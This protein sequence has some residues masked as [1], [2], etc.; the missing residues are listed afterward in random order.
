MTNSQT[1]TTHVNQ[2]VAE[3]LIGRAGITRDPDGR[4]LIPE[5]ARDLIGAHPFTWATDEALT[6]ALVILATAD[7]EALTF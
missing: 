7:V 4:W 6:W 3:S 1:V 2:S 5:E